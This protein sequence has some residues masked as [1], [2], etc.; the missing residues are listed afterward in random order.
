MGD[1][2]TPQFLPRFLRALAIL[3]SIPGFALA[4]N[5]DIWAPQNN[6][7]FN[8]TVASL[9]WDVTDPNWT[10]N[11]ANNQTFQNGD[12]VYFDDLADPGWNNPG[13]GPPYSPA[14]VFLTQNV[15]PGSITVVS[16]NIGSDFT[17]VDY[18]QGITSIGNANSDTP[19][20]L[21]KLGP[22]GLLFLDG[23]DSDN[24]LFTGAITVYQGT[25]TEN[26][27]SFS[28][29]FTESNGGSFD[30]YFNH[31]PTFELFSPS[32]PLVM[33][34][35]RI[36]VVGQ[37]LNYNYGWQTFNNTV[38][39]SGSSGI[40]VQTTTNGESTTIY[41]TQITRNVGGVV[42][43]GIAP[44]INGYGASNAF[45]TSNSNT[46]G[47]LGGWATYG[48]TEWASVQ[49]GGN[50]VPL[51]ANGGY[52]TDAWGSADNTDV[53]T[54]EA[55]SST[56]SLR[57]NTANSSTVTLSGGSVI[58]SGGILIT[59]NVG[60]HNLSITGGTLASGNGQDLIV[61]QNNSAGS[62]SISSQI[63]G[64]TGLTLAGAGT[65]SL[66]AQNNYTGITTINGGWSAYTV[67]GTSP[68]QST[69]G[70]QTTASTLSVT[71]L[72]NG[73]SP[74]GIG[75]SS[76]AASNLVIDGATLRYVGA[77]GSTDRLFT[78]GPSGASLDASGSGAIQFTNPGS[79]V[80][81][82]NTT[83]SLT[84]TG[85]STASN[86]LSAI[87]PDPTPANSNAPAYT[88][89]LTKSGPGTWALAGA[90]TYS[91][92]TTLSSGTLTIQNTT[93]S[94]TGSGEVNVNG[95][96]LINNGT[97]LSTTASDTLV[98]IGQ[99]GTN[100]ATL[101]NNGTI[102]CEGA[103]QTVVGV[104]SGQAGAGQFTIIN[105][106]TIIAGPASQNGPLYV[107]E[108]T[109][110]NNPGA[111]IIGPSDQ[112][113]LSD[114]STFVNNGMINSPF[115]GLQGTISGTGTFAASYNEIELST[116]QPDNGTSPGVMTFENFLQIDEDTTIAP[117]LD[118]P[119]D[120]GAAGGNDLLDVTAGDSGNGDLN[121]EDTIFFPVKAGPD[122]AP[123]VYQLI[124]YTGALT[125][126]TSNFLDWN[127]TIGTDPANTP[128]YYF[129][130]DAAN[131]NVNLVITALGLTWNNAAA[132][133]LWNTADA[134]WSNGTSNTRYFQ[135]NNVT[136]DDTC[137]DNY[138]VTLSS[139]VN[140]ASV[141]VNSTG[142]YSI[143]GSGLINDA[144][145][146]TKSGT[147][148]LT[149]GVGLTSS[150]FSITGGNVVLAKG[151]TAGTGSVAH[152][153]SNINL[154]SLTI[155]TGSVFDITNNHVIIDYTP[156]NDPISTIYGYLKSGFN[157][158]SWNGTTGIISST[159]QSSTN[160][161][162]YGIGWADGG[163]GT[164]NVAGLATGQIELRYTL[165]GDA[166]LDGTVNGTDFSILAA[167]FGLGDTNWDQGNF[168]YGSSVNGSDFSALAA[169]FGQGDSGAAV[170]V[171]PADIAAL[172]SFA[173][174][175]GLPL[176][177]IEAVPEPTSVA[178]G[179]GLFLG[180]LTRRNRRA[181]CS[182]S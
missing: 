124:H 107:S 67:S 179:I 95:G 37:G 162:H 161:L 8:N 2:C 79:I 70:P 98:N 57:F 149:L 145:A 53:T 72:A 164:H 66:T 13:D 135:N 158:G 166:N 92:G 112:Y 142:N 81:S 100:N 155:A 80:I 180:L 115:L 171:T 102:D 90:D 71:S 28:E 160:G 134:N 39:A 131:G 88:M 47:I 75:T 84:L 48:T 61:F 150:S 26:L 114:T 86:L 3:L 22:G 154:S 133:G 139:T 11:G 21:T 17:I 56:N 177:A 5:T 45:N 143:T 105:N 104:A 159:A 147:S 9:S 148:T 38:I 118:R 91:G 52:N 153:A 29:F 18:S 25:L 20:T 24:E 59:P 51:S 121:L 46:N 119:N 31:N 130:F 106:G 151:T 172:N 113:V 167:N 32:S 87:I 44:E 117:I 169:N 175:N 108:G 43:F 85:A 99:L 14:A 116:I 109:F 96:E 30:Y 49:S 4:Q 41:L 16:H 126:D 129:T 77:G 110:I 141:A 63:T 62:L 137:N 40:D 176:P 132:T 50:I 103:G 54:S 123:G 125:D 35:G 174:A 1:K 23:N 15:N 58:S 34:G 73:G 170:S 27:G 138:S 82:Q 89:S 12:N 42:D 101:I 93:G 156:G 178:T 120:F 7:A 144:G 65:L 157:N 76:N 182:H 64:S 146:F 111:N 122:F 36:E 33:A 163:D 83:E 94:G 10:V 128:D 165:L 6:P 55:G 168:L 97:I 173:I 74:S 181:F 68:S 69:V 127:V 19:T 152:P 60:A 78:I 140:P 136:F